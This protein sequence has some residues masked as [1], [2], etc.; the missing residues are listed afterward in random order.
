MKTELKLTGI[1]EVDERLG[2]LPAGSLVCIYADPI[3]TP[4]LILYEIACS[5]KT[6]YFNTSRP[7]QYIKRDM[8]LLNLN[9]QN[10]EFIDVYTQYYLNEYGQ[11][12]IEDDFRKKEI[13]D[14]VGYALS[15]II[16]NND[17][18]DY[19]LIFDNISFFLKLNVSYGLKE[20]LINKLYVISKQTENLCF[21]YL[22]KDVHPKSVVNMVLELSDIVLDINRDNES[23][24]INILKTRYR[25]SDLLPAPR[26]EGSRE[27]GEV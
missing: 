19:N 4:E 6:Y 25:P 14:F 8:E 17:G 11:F 5:K 12:I 15:R 3:S 21:I 1:C 23:I 10:V 2:G 16:E 13:F 22:M 24:K 7:S 18:K 9:P 27:G 26:C 20:W